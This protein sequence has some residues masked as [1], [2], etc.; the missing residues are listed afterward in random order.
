MSADVSTAV[1]APALTVTIFSKNDCAICVNTE[2]TFAKKGVPFTEINV[3]E[4]L[5]P[6]AEFGGRAPLDHVV[7]TFGRQMPVVIIHDDNGFAVDSWT[8]ANMLKLHETIKR[9]EAEGLLIP[10]DERQA[11]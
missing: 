10:E 8:G 5:E 3:Q 1:E 2:N 4:D 6:R 9:F 11:A 7:E